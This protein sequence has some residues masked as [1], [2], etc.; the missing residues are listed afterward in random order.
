MIQ[1]QQLKQM[2]ER[3]NQSVLAR[4]SEKEYFNNVGKNA[5]DKYYLNQDRKDEAMAKLK[6]TSKRLAEE[7]R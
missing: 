4:M 3:K 2:Q 7:L 6:S 1:E 5:S